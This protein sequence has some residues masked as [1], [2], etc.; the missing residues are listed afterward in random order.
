MVI[1]VLL[2]QTVQAYDTIGATWPQNS[3]PIPYTVQSELG[4]S[5]DDAELLAAIQAGFTTWEAVE[6]A[7]ISFDY[8]G[9]S[10]ATRFG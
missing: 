6:C 8:Q 7:G 5:L 3:I 1:W 4:L 10:E 2:T 9:R